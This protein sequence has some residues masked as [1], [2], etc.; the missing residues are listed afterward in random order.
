MS[1]REGE[2]TDTAEASAGSFEFKFKIVGPL[3]RSTLE[4]GHPDPEWEALTDVVHWSFCSR[5]QAE[6]LGK[7]FLAEVPWWSGLF[8]FQRKRFSTT[9]YDEH[10]LMVA[11]GNLDRAMHK[12]AKYLRETPLPT[13]RLR[14]FRDAELVGYE[15]SGGGYFLTVKH[16]LVPKE[17]VVC[18]ATMV[19]ARAEEV[20]GG[21]IAFLENDELMLECYTAGAMDVPEGFR[22][23]HVEITQPNKSLERTRGR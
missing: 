4:A 3:K 15:Y 6:R 23:L 19:V 9:S 18:S 7:S 5:L 2:A 13:Q 14:A 20:E 17:R 12:G 11:T 10:C 22:D 1:V 21:Y 16:D 8:A